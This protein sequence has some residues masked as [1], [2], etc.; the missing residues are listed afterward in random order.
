LQTTVKSS[1]KLDKKKTNTG[2]NDSILHLPVLVEEIL[3]FLDPKEGQIFVDGTLGL[4]GHAKA[5]L[6]HINKIALL[7]GVDVDPKSLEI[8]TKNLKDFG[9]RVRLIRSSYVDIPEVLVSEEIEKVDAI[10][11]DLGLSS[12]QLEH[13]G[14]GFS[15]TRD[16]P[17]DMRMDPSISVTASD[18]VNKLPFEQLA[19]LIRTY[20]EERWAK[21]IAKTIVKKRRKS[22]IVSSKQLADIVALA[23]PRKY[24]PRRIHPAT[25]TFQALRIAVNRELDQ[26]KEALL[27]L[28]DCL[29][30]GGKIAIISFHSLEDRLVKHAFKHDPRLKVLTKKPITATDDEISHNPRS[31]SAKLRVAQRTD[32]EP[33]NIN[34]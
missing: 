2:G 23:I 30:Q 3:G 5:I 31:R 28:P 1:C 20:G 15:F 12:F 32:Y 25:K 14:R 16:E 6:N 29:K 21:K 13:S 9:D 17:L 24:H 18:M 4:G 27:R 34:N 8:A 26:I 10:L 19:Q 22:P 33:E 11:L 7:I